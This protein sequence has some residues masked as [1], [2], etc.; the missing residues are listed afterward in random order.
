M[1]TRSQIE[2][3]TGCDGV[4]G[5]VTWHVP[6]ELNKIPDQTIRTYSPAVILPADKEKSCGVKL[7]AVEVSKDRWVAKFTQFTGPWDKG[8]V[9]VMKKLELDVCN[10]SAS[11]VQHDIPVDDTWKIAEYRVTKTYSKE[12]LRDV[13][14][15]ESLKAP[16]QQYVT[17]YI[18]CFV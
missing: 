11:L 18:W 9:V 3:F 8:A 14:V 10:I 13:L 6:M 4:F 1:G 15:W 17:S 2:E 16:I 7:E 12:A 5:T